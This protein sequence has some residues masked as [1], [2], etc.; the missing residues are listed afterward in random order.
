MSDDLKAPCPFCDEKDQIKKSL[1]LMAYGV[2]LILIHG[3]D[4]EDNK[5]FIEDTIKFSK[6]LRKIQ[7]GIED[8]KKDDPHINVDHLIKPNS[9]EL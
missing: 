3:K 8:Y 2:G 6:S 5:E 7:K 9:Y 1:D 4:A